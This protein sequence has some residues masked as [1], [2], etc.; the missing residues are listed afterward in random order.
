MPCNRWMRAKMVANTFRGIAASIICKNTY[1][2]C[3]RTFALIVTSLSHNCLGDQPFHHRTPLVRAGHVAI[4]QQ[5]SFRVTHVM[6][7][8]DRW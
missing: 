6:E 4:P 8:E 2:E 3:D 5:R 7:A 1:R